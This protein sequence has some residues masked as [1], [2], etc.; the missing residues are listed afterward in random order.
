MIGNIVTKILNRLFAIICLIIPLHILKETLNSILFEIE[1]REKTWIT[2]HTRPKFASAIG[3]FSDKL[4]FSSKTAIVIQGPIIKDEDFTLETIKIYKKNFDDTIII[5]ST[6]EDENKD[7]LEKIKQEG[8]EIVLCKKP[9]YPG[10][11][12]INFQITTSIE[13]LRLAK[14]YGVDFALKTRTDQRM[15]APNIK[16]FLCNI[17]EE[18]PVIPGYMQKMRIVGVSLNTFKYRLYGLSDMN[19][20]GQIDDLLLYWGVDLDERRFNDKEISMANCS[21]KNWAEWRV[22]EVYL[23]TEFLKKIGRRLEWTLEDS[24]K[25]YSDHCCIVDKEI[26][27]L[28]WYKYERR[29]EYRYLC[30]DSIRANHELNF[31]EWLNLHN[32]LNNKRNIPEEVLDINFTDVVHNNSPKIAFMQQETYIKN[33]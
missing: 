4:K 26:L 15:Y 29:K 28:Y 6:W 23:I 3:T 18:F 11:S 9:E 27:D 13:G 7:Y 30:Y 16:E 21:I 1:K 17:I 19:I 25:V 24:W 12:N 32:N 22:C 14:E 31:R 10:I 33:R 8:I 2:H 20:F 5:L